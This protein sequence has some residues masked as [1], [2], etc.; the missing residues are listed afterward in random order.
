MSSTAESGE[1]DGRPTQ[2]PLSVLVT[3]YNEEEVLRGALASVVGW[4]ADLLVVVDPRTTDRSRVIALSA[5]ARVLEHP[6]ESSAA[7]LAWGM[8]NCAHDWVF[9]LDA[10]ERVSGRLAGAI[11]DVMWAPRHPAYSVRRLNLVLGRPVHFGDWGGDRVVRLLDR[12]LVRLEGGMHWRV[13]AGTTGHLRERLEHL[14]LRSMEQY[15][16]KLHDYAFRGA[17]A[18]RATG[19]RGGVV[20]GCGHAGW[21]FVRGYVL[22]LGFLDGTRGLLV[23]ALQAWGSFVKRATVGERGATDN[24]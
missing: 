8:E 17:A 24:L 11:R 2:V 4:A 22:R 14:T 15:L 19:G 10:D 16:P 12:R 21:R 3:A 7:Q 13:E 20:S 23:A 5:G 1:A 6:F 9:V 18:L